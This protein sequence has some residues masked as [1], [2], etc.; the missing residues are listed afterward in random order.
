MRALALLLTVLGVGAAPNPKT[1][2]LRASDFPV[3]VKLSG[4]SSSSGPGG[5][6]YSSSFNFKVDGREDEV[7]DKVWFVPPG[8]KSPTPGLV[9]GV[10]ATYGGEVSQIS[11]F[12]GERPL[13]LPQY[14][15]EQTANWADYKNSDGVR[16]AR[17]ALVVRKNQVVWTIVVERCGVLAPS[18]CFF[19]PTPAKIGQAEA[20]AE[21][22]KYAAKLERRVGNG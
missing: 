3:G 4:I 5:S 10:K 19:G 14:G 21:L 9:G 1:L 7:T 12:P 17:A 13:S 16:R 22:E 18:G 6:V 15:D 8:A 2:A 11:G 20:V